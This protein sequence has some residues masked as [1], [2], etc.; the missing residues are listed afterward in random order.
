MQTV[1]GLMDFPQKGG[2]HT[3]Q[4][5]SEKKCHPEINEGTFTG[6][7]KNIVLSFYQVL[8]RCNIS[9]KIVYRNAI[10]ACY[11]HKKRE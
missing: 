4:Q 6:N 10:C 3:K 11:I 5:K 9:D 1:N 7:T 8:K 2:L